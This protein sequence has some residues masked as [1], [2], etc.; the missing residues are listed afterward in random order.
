MNEIVPGV[1]HWKAHHPKIG[2]E[3]SCYYLLE[4]RVLIDPMAPDEGLDWFR[5][6]G[7]PEHILLSN[8]HHYRD[9]AAFVD[10]F[11]CTV[12]GSRPGMHEFAD[13]QPVEPF[14]FGDELPGGVKAYEAGAICPDD[15]ALH[16]PARSA[17]SV[18]DGVINYGGLGIVPDHHLGDDVE[19]T[20]R[21]IRKSYARIA[22]EAEFD[23]LLVAHG[24]PIVGGGREALREFAEG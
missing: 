14:D 2:A 22:A 17:L 15:T 6:R 4:E 19:A 5:E 13:Y 11:G 24:D 18:A 9:S 12:Y 23:N 10:A 20:K 16:I 1:F 8:R 21:A 7:A 3:V